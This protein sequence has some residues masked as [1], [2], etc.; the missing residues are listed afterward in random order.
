MEGMRLR[1]IFMAV[2][3]LVAAGCASFDGRGLIP[4]KA[5]QGE[6]EALVGAPAHRIALPNGDSAHYFS[7]LLEGARYS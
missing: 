4:G 2:T 1:N 3:V 6:V 7:R 5:T